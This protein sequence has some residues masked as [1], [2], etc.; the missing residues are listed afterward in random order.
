MEIRNVQSTNFG[1]AYKKLSSTKELNAKYLSS[2]ET[3]ELAELNENMKKATEALKN[4]AYAHLHSW[5][6]EKD[7]KLKN[8]IEYYN[9]YLNKDCN[10]A[11]SLAQEVTSEKFDDAINQTLHID[12][13]VADR[14][15]AMQ[16]MA[17]NLKTEK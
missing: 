5:I 12:K 4:T 6:D 15:V 16:E 8:Y 9:P 10:L 3:K 11:Y 1:M 17:D 13:V 2:L 14:R 7:M